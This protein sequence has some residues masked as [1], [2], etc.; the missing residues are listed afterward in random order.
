MSWRRRE[1]ARDTSAI[2]VYVRAFGLMVGKGGFTCHILHVCD[3][4]TA[5]SFNK[6]SKHMEIDCIFLDIRWL[7]VCSFI[8]FLFL[9]EGDCAV[10]SIDWG[11][12][13]GLVF[14]W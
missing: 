8:S 3:N 13:R 12:N 11:I 4:L 10:L 2:Q 6:V 9:E 14:E 7:V 1:G 5:V